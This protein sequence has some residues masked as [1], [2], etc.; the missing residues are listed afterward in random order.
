MQEVTEEDEDLLSWFVDNSSLLF[1]NRMQLYDP[2][3]TISV[4]CV[5][6]YELRLCSLRRPTCNV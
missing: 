1:S 2:F 5:Q 4:S 3:C 6:P